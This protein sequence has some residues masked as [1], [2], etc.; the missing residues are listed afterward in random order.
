MKLGI[1][2]GSKALPVIFRLI[3]GDIFDWQYWYNQGIDEATKYETAAGSTAMSTQGKEVNYAKVV[4]AK[5]ANTSIAKTYVAVINGEARVYVK[6]LKAGTTSVTVK[7]TLNDGK[8]FSYV[9]TVTIGSA[10]TPISYTTDVCPTSYA[11]YSVKTDGAHWLGYL[12]KYGSFYSTA[13]GGDKLQTIGH[14]NTTDDLIYGS[15]K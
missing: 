13:T 12:S 4:T 15:V 1:Q 9:T 14:P 8:T 5:V 3:T 6:G 2:F 7:T 10:S 11:A